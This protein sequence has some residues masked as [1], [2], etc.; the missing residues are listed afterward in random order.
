M[1]AISERIAVVADGMNLFISA[2][3]RY[4][5]NLDYRELL[6]EVSGGRRIGSRPMLITT[7]IPNSER[8]VQ[9]MKMWWDVRVVAPKVLPD[10]QTKD[11]TD[12]HIMEAIAVCT[13]SDVDTIVLLSGDSD[14]APMLRHAKRRGKRIEVAGIPGTV[15]W[16]LV[17]I[18]DKVHYIGENLLYAA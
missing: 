12:G 15:A 8:F 6:D 3:T 2:K 4:G 10:G 7:R 1:D 9:C 18:A 16:E 11:M 14:F 5:S 13:D 17:H